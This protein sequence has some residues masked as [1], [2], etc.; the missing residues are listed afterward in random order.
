MRMLELATRANLLTLQKATPEI[1]HSVSKIKASLKT[2]GFYN[3]SINEEYTADFFESLTAFQ[4]AAGLSPADGIFGKD[5]F[6]E[7]LR[8]LHPEQFERN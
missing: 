4:R 7:L 2:L 3:G 8:R 1:E 5:T 6:F